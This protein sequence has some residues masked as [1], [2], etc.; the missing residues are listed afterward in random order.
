MPTDEAPSQGGPAVDRTPDPQPQWE[1]DRA[2]DWDRFSADF[3]PGA[4]ARFS[5]PA[6]PVRPLSVPDFVTRK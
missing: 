5:Q 6:G 2:P 1:C 3:L 4:K